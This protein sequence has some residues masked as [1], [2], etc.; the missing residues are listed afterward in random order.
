MIKSV[1]APRGT[2]STLSYR[3]ISYDTRTQKHVIRRLDNQSRMAVIHD[4]GLRDIVHKLRS[5]CPAYEYR[6]LTR[7]PNVRWT[8]ARRREPRDLYT[9]KVH[10]P[11]TTIG[12]RPMGY[13]NSY[14][15]AKILNVCTRIRFTRH[16]GHVQYN[17]KQESVRSYKSLIGSLQDPTIRIHH[18]EPLLDS[19]RYLYPNLNNHNI[20]ELLFI[21]SIFIINYYYELPSVPLNCLGHFEF[22]L[23]QIS[24][25]IYAQISTISY[26]KYSN[27]KRNSVL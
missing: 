9:C 16:S 23:K 4:S 21:T 10:A 11:G 19:Y 6:F 5:Q 8:D 24:T 17:Q 7:R 14:V 20:S 3:A 13:T 12:T 2:R 22:K 15:G 1:M 26:A 25:K 18:T 27:K